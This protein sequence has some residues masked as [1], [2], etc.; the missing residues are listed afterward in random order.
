LGRCDLSRK[1]PPHLLQVLP[2]FGI[3]ERRRLFEPRAREPQVAGHTVALVLDRADCGN[4]R[5][6]SNARLAPMVEF[7]Y[8]ST[9]TK[10]THLNIKN[11]E[12][13]KLATELAGLPGESL[14]S[15]VTLALR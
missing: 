11:G 7:V 6:G 10:A 5:L 12:A 8:I 13:H 3:A 15:A 4:F 2:G 9:M 14:T 1:S